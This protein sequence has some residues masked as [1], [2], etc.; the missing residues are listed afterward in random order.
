MLD[1]AGNLVK[2]IL[3]LCRSTMIPT[4]TPSHALCSSNIMALRM[5]RST[6]FWIYRDGYTLKLWLIRSMQPSCAGP[7]IQFGRWMCGLIIQLIIA[8]VF[9]SLLA[10]FHTQFLHWL[11]KSTRNS[12]TV[13]ASARQCR[14]F[15]TFWRN[16]P[17]PYAVNL[18]RIHELIERK[19]TLI[20]PCNYECM[21]PTWREM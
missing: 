14:L 20:C 17:M 6:D 10:C 19:N 21:A 2:R 3:D 12:S 18:V 16:R 15:K 4:V 5:L 9:N 1:G 13:A 11:D 8:T 7:V